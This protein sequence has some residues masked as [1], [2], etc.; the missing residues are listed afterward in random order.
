MFPR[1]RRIACLASSSVANPM[2]ASPSSPPTMCT[3]PS[4]IRRPEKNARTS[5][6]FADNGNNCKRIITDIANN[7]SYFTSLF[8][9]L[10]INALPSEIEFSLIIMH[11][12]D[13]PLQKT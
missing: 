7:S 12:V 13:S 3:A 10:V 11:K 6:A 5:A 1:S 4:G 2:N 8:R 9:I